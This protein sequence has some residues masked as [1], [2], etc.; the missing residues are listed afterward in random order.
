MNDPFRNIQDYE[1]VLYTLT[2]QH[3][4]VAR[5]TLVLIHVGVSMAKISGEIYFH[6][7]I[8]LVVRERLIFDRLPVVIDAYGY[9]IWDGE[10]ILFWYDSQPHP[11]DSTLQ[12][13]HPHH[14][15]IPPDI[16]HHRIP[17]PE[18]SFTQP[19]LPA[20]IHEIETLR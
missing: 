1:L 10:E 3:S 4:S 7:G 17:A 8:R 14:K 9:E 16:K 13:T 6:N 12:S 11:N 19:N 2:E 5:S 20:L 15:H 18:M